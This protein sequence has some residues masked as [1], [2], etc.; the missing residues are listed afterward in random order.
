MEELLGA[1]AL[2]AVDADD[3]ARV[4]AYLAVNPAARAEVDELRETAGWLAQTASEP[5]AELWDRIAASLPAA[6]A[7]PAAPELPISKPGPSVT[8]AA[9]AA[10]SS[11]DE[12]RA[13]KRIVP[14]WV[15][16]VAGV[17]AALL[18]VLMGAQIVSQGNKVDKLQRSISNPDALRRAAEAAKLAP[19]AQQVTL[20]STSGNAA[21][22]LVLLPSGAGYLEE[23]NLP[24]L[25]AGETYQLWAVMDDAQSS[26]V[27]SAGVLGRQA[28]VT[29]FRVNGKVV[30]FAVTAEKSPGVVAS[31]N[32]PVV[33]G[34]LS[35]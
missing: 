7:R 9:P 10:V 4:E 35:A 21:A 15:T 14:R 6:P 17:A 34:K 23:N 29:P 24:T 33:S 27:I 22:S 11:L 18:V 2:D 26:T 31:K 20:K 30:A 16:A 32:K 28:P 3:R 25:P 12:A 5:P 8:L 19:G 13:R 1:Y